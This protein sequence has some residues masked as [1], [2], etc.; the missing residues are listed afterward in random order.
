V[1]GLAGG[2]G[3]MAFFGVPFFVLTWHGFEAPSPRVLGTSLLVVPLIAFG[4]SAAA[5]TF[6]VEGVKRYRGEHGRVHAPGSR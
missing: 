1:A 2:L 4:L 5:A 3:T 6:L